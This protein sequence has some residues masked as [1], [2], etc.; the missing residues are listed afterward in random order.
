MLRIWFSLYIVCVSWECSSQSIRKKKGEGERT[1]GEAK[2]SMSESV[3]KSVWPTEAVNVCDSTVLSESWEYMLLTYCINNSN[4]FFNVF[5]FLCL[6]QVTN[7]PTRTRQYTFLKIFFSHC[8]K[9]ILFDIFHLRKHATDMSGSSFSYDFFF[10]FF[11]MIQR[12]Q[13][14]VPSRI[15]A[16]SL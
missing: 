9:A 8:L 11:C 6:K 7:V 5:R 3:W 4:L 1:G 12:I 10:F 2:D 13:I 16:L 15:I 14:I